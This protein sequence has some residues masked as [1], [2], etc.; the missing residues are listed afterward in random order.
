MSPA[1][2]GDISGGDGGSDSH[3]QRHPKWLMIA[4]DLSRQ[5]IDGSICGSL[6]TERQLAAFY[7]VSLQPIR[8]ALVAL[9]DAGLVRFAR[10]RPPVTVLHPQ[11]VRI[12]LTGTAERWFG[13][14]QRLGHTVASTGTA[15][16]GPAG[17]VFG[18]PRSGTSYRSERLWLVDAK[19]VAVDRTRWHAPAL[20][21]REGAVPRRLA[22][23]N[24]AGAASEAPEQPVTVGCSGPGCRVPVDT[25]EW[26]R[27]GLPTAR[28]RSLLELRTPRPLWIV[29]ALW[30]RHGRLVGR[31]QTVIHAEQHPIRLETPGATMQQGS[32]GPG[33]F[34][35]L[36]SS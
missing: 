28:I 23:S 19:P 32:Y 27:V 20:E 8:S 6:P 26:I 24:S 12:C 22:R 34:D 18:C 36:A 9:S 35:I 31:R 7:G 5:I 16:G 33:A 30:S 3:Q 1:R 2:P 10:G 11:H 25:V 17:T 4:S 14:W 21:R 29:T 13:Q 15:H